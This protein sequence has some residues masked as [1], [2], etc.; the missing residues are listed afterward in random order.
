MINI[1]KI[2]TNRILQISF[3]AILSLTIGLLLGLLMTSQNTPTQTTNSGQIVRKAY[4]SSLKDVK[5]SQ[6]ASLQR[7]IINLKDRSLSNEKSNAIFKIR[8]SE[9]NLFN[10]FF[11]IYATLDVSNQSDVEIAQSKLR[12]ITKV[13][14]SDL[15]KNK[16]SLNDGVSQLVGTV[17][18]S[19]L[20]LENETLTTRLIVTTRKGEEMRQSV[21]TSQIKNGVIETLTF[22]GELKIANEL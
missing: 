7:Q 10:T 6:I 15:L 14:I 11:E 8:E 21:Y 9:F 20:D 17:E 16:S 1:K 3:A 22:I 19:I 2:L 12:G 5:D 4:S 18:V 13:N